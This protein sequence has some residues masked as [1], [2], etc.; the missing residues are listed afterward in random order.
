MKERIL[1][2]PRNIFFLGLTSLFNDFSSEMVFAAF[3]AFFTSVLKSGAA[4]LGLVDGVAEAVSNFFKIYSG[5]LS[6]VSQKRKPL[7]V[8]GYIFSVA[9]RPFYILVSTVTGVLGL[10]VFDRVGKGLRDSPRDAIISLS[11]PKEELGRSFGYHRA[12]DT[13]GAILGPLAAYFVLRYFPLRFDILFGTA[14]LIGILALLALFFISDVVVGSSSKRGIH[15]D[16][17]RQ[18]PTQFKVTLF[19]ILILSMGSLPIAVMLLK[20]RSLGLIVA[21]IPLFYAVYSISYAAFSIPAGK[22]SDRI[23]ARS[24]I[25]IGYLLL[26]VGYFI[27]NW[28]F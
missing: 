28:A 22:I 25:V 19:A 2:L 5:R 10:R 14:F 4:S 9:I 17:F 20:T 26:V 18:L 15:L 7:V 21:D 8:W 27:L 11:T 24:V 23:G 3:P 1:G 13:T 16:Y 12:M 6:D